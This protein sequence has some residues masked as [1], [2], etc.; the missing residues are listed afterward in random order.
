MLC[1]AA[2][3]VNEYFFFSL[4]C[5][6]GYVSYVWWDV[7]FILFYNCLVIRS[8]STPIEIETV[9]KIYV[10]YFWN[11]RD[12]HR[13]VCSTFTLCNT[14]LL[15][16]AHKISYH[17][18]NFYRLNIYFF[19]LSILCHTEYLQDKRKPIELLVTVVFFCCFVCFLL[20]FQLAMRWAIEN[21]V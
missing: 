21:I 15:C 20:K 14:K 7:I 6:C 3:T 16:L 18:A 2:S 4:V 9:T 8:Y 19:L 11:E 5:S 13:T 10:G 1:A 17:L 12:L